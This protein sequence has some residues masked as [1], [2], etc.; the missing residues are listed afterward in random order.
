MRLKG[1]PM[2]EIS[3]TDN[4]REYPNEYTEVERPMLVQLAEMGWQYVRG[5]LD[6]PQKTF[7]ERFRDVVLRDKL[8]QA[9]R[10]INRDENGNEFLDDVTIDRAIREF[11]TTTE[12]SLFDRNRELTEKRIRGVFVEPAEGTADAGQRSQWVK[13]I[14]FDP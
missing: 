3:L 10:R 7:R 8:R 12:Y 2:V 5:D 11:L 4:E 9:I 13:L 6:Y 1:L 14:E